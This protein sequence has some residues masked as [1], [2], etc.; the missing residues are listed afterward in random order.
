MRR[1]KFP[2]YGDGALN[3][4][5]QADSSRTVAVIPVTVIPERTPARDST[6]VC[7]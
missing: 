7:V 3:P 6:N 2:D 1:S 5:T 4:I